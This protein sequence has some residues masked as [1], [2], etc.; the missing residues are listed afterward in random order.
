MAKVTK[1]M[2][3]FA[4]ET[5]LRILNLL[6]YSPMYVN[7]ISDSLKIYQSKLSHQLSILKDSKL[8]KAKK[9]G[10]TIIY[11]LSISPEMRPYYKLV[12]K[13]FSKEKIFSK[14]IQR[15]KKLM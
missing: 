15:A 13:A 1:T 9:K 4:N 10:K 3:V 11:R 5:R 14:D 2:K 8:V 6:S 12:S 7:L